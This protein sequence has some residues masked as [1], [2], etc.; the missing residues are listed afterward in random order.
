MLL[1]AG[2]YITATLVILQLPLF[3]DPGYEFAAAAAAVASVVAGVSS[4]FR[5]ARVG[6]DAGRGSDA[7]LRATIAHD[8][9]RLLRTQ[10]LLATTPLLVALPVWAIRT[11]CGVEDV[12]T[13]FLL[14]APPSAIISCS[15]GLLCE[16][17]TQR[18]WIGLTLFVVLWFTSL[19]RGGIEALVGPHIF[20]YTWHIG[21]FP[22]GSWSADQPVP[23]NLLLYRAVGIVTALALCAVSWALSLTV[24]TPIT[25][26]KRRRLL[27]ALIVT[28][29][30]TCAWLSA[31]EQLGYA[32]SYEYVEEELGDSMRCTYA[33]IRFRRASVDSLYLWEAA[34]IVDTALADH[35][36][37][38]GVDPHRMPRTQVYL[39]GSEEEEQ[40][41]VGPRSLAYTKPWQQSVH[42]Q[43]S[44]VAYAL[45]HELAHVAL[46]P[47]GFVLGI[48]LSQGLLEGSA[49]ALEGET[50]WRTLQQYARAAYAAGLA[51]SAEQ[52]MGIGGFSSIRPQLAYRL[53]GAFSSWLVRTYGVRRYLEALPTG[54]LEGT[55]GVDD[56]ILAK[57]FRESLDSLPVPDSLELV[58]ARYRFGG[59][60]FFLQRCLR[61][62][63]T[64]NARGER[65]LE[66]GSYVRAIEYFQ[67]SLREGV[68][69]GARSGILRAQ[70]AMGRWRQV[71]DSLEYYRRDS[72]GIAYLGFEV[73]RGDALWSLGEVQRARDCYARIFRYDISRSLTLRAA[74]RM[75]FID[76]PSPLRETMRDYFARPLDPLGRVAVLNAAESEASDH[77]Q[78]LV[79][80]FMKAVLTSHRSPIA[81]IT[82][83]AHELGGNSAVDAPR[84]GRPLH[85]LFALRELARD[86][87]SP[88]ELTVALGVK[89]TRFD[90][91]EFVARNHCSD[92]PMPSREAALWP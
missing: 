88:S 50:E 73:E 30:V 52:I 22:G 57:R 55:Y 35:A 24:R 29:F 58:G 87:I 32:R 17:V 89:M 77:E 38:L 5:T 54:D 74:L 80:L 10:T 44:A 63:G 37:F 85:L 19:A 9:T 72:T 67:E 82:G 81:T 31:R 62:I 15:I 69:V 48:P 65:A 20:L 68:S 39:Y 83:L 25:G 64:L 23:D 75:Y 16:S 92:L 61:R 71:L 36:R 13:W 1:I 21:Y 46:A 84:N 4:L 45:R 12:L 41:M 26:Q 27:A 91:H 14:L 40:R 51:P 6:P 60:G 42:L 18:R 78:R 33:T 11:S 47:Y 2:A 7:E 79:L 70:M 66:G 43:A 53:A 8:I 59:G 34:R 28:A 56:T 86:L 90:P 3:A 76:T 49:V